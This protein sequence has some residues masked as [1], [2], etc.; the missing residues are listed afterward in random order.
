MRTS[1]IERIELVELIL[2]RTKR[3]KSGYFRGGGL[4][5]QHYPIRKETQLVH[6]I[7]S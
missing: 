1:L 7:L 6:E 3:I 4:P 5:V 2:A